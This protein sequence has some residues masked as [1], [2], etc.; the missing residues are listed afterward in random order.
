MKRR[1]S[2]FEYEFADGEDETYDVVRIKPAG[3]AMVG[4]VSAPTGSVVH[5]IF[6]DARRTDRLAQLGFAAWIDAADTWAVASDAAE[7]ALDHEAADVARSHEAWW[8]SL[9]GP[10]P[11]ILEGPQL[12]WPIVDTQTPSKTNLLRKLTANVLIFR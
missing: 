9:E 3:S 11:S 2:L 12:P 4:A 7:E 10:P 5:L 1:Y 8:R 6:D